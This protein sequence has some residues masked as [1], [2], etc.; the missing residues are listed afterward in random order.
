MPALVKSSVGSF[1]GTSEEL[2]TRR[3]WRSSK[4]RRKASRMSAAVAFFMAFSRGKDRSDNTG[5][6]EAQ[7]PHGLSGGQ[8]ALL[9]GGG[10]LGRIVGRED[11]LAAEVLEAD[12]LEPCD[13]VERVALHVGAEVEQAAGAQEPQD[14]PGHRVVHQPAPVVAPLPP[15][16][17]EV[18]VDG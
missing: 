13:G 4:K 7:P 12:L 18:D 10:E 11:A 14:E 6:G 15:G 2:F 9:A 8:V 3:C 5:S 1:C 17:G 16:V